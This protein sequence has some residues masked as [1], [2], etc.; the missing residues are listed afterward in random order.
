MKMIISELH[1]EGYYNAVALNLQQKGS[2]LADLVRCEIQTVDKYFYDKIAP[3]T[4]VDVTTRH[5]DTPLIETQ[6]DRRM[7]S[8]ITSDWAD[9]IDREDQL[10]VIYDPTKAYALNAA[11]ALGRKKD[12]RI[13][14]AALGDSYT[15]NRGEIAVP[16]PE[17]QI[18]SVDYSDDGVSIEGESSGLTIDKLRKARFLLDDSDMDDDEEQYLVVTPKQI[19]DLLKTTE[20]TSEDYNT[21]KSLVDGKINTFMGFKFKKVSS[22]LLP[23]DENNVRKI[24]CFAKSGILLAMAED[25]KTNVSVRKDKRMAVQVYASLSCGAT[26]MDEKKVVAI[27]CSE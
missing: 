22:A 4:A 12:E 8:L 2:R 21:V 27:M 1:N 14:N 10:K 15:G 17:S 9:L 16:L 6:F 25:I 20:V 24:F 19:Y 18:I 5:D 7:V 11:Y 3:T 23:K 13:I 26:R